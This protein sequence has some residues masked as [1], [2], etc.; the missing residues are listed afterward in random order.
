MTTCNCTGPINGQ[1]FCPCQMRLMEKPSNLDQVM[2]IMH[3]NALREAG[4]I[5]KDE[6]RLGLATFEETPAAHGLSPLTHQ[7][8]GEQ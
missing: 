4:I 3:L 8:R 2:A 6:V 5:G 1:L 7:E